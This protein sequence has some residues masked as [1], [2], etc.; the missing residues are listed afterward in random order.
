MLNGILA[1]GALIVVKQGGK[2]IV[3]TEEPSAPSG[4]RAEG[5]WVDNGSEIRMVYEFVPED[6]TV[7]D[8]AIRYVRSLAESAD[9]STAVRYKAL[10]EDWSPGAVDYRTGDLRNYAGELYRCTQDH[11]SQQA[12]TPD[13]SSYWKAVPASGRQEWNEELASSGSINVGDILYHDGKEWISLKDAN[14]SE[15]GKDEW[16]DEYTGAA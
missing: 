5:R 4:Y 15:P 3:E 9:D 16:W 1:D 11:T 7:V 6:G 14:S 8:A 10:Y 13:K 12:Q 2:P